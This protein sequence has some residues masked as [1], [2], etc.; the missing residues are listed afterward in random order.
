MPPTP[1]KP[2]F[3][4]NKLKSIFKF[5]SNII[6]KPENS[7]AKPS[8]NGKEFIEEKIDLL[9]KY[10]AIKIDICEHNYNIGEG[11]FWNKYAGFHIIFRN[12]I[13]K[14]RNIKEALKK[15]P[16]S[17]RKRIRETID[18][19]MNTSNEELRE[20]VEYFWGPENQAAKRAQL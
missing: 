14:V 18:H 1:D 3:L 9:I 8:D 13:Q 16:C 4:S 10:Q 6:K 19:V 7:E 11:D 17:G 15:V 5:L 12:E 2:N 20:H